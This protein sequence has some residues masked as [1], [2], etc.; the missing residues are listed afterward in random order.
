MAFSFKSFFGGADDDEKEY[1]DANYEQQPAQAQRNPNP[2]AQTATAQNSANYQGRGNYG[3]SN[4]YRQQPRMSAV[5]SSTQ[6][7]NNSAKIDSHIALFVP[8]VFSDAKTIVNQLL[9]HEA[10]IVNF[11]AIDSTQSSKIVDFV[12]GAIYAVEGS[13]EKISDDIW[14]IAPNNYAV[15]GSGSAADAMG[16]N[17]RF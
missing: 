10:V 1:E 15:S 13:I 3:Y 14:L 4:E 7:N 11:S 2:Q 5:G 16:Q 17:A 8:K 9:L 12:A 6:N